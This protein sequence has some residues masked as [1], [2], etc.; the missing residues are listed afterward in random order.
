MAKTRHG[1]HSPF[2]YGF[3]EQVLLSTSVAVPQ[4][5]IIE[6]DTMSIPTRYQCLLGRINEYCKPRAIQIIP[7]DRIDSFIAEK[8][9]LIGSDEVILAPS[10]H[11]TVEGSA[12]WARLINDPRVRLSIDLYG[13][14]LLF[15]NKEFKEQQHFILKY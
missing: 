15:F 5:P 1:V 3:I 6:G 14:G 4:S 12:A 7:I 11:S 8:L 10:I 9:P 13:I 2:V